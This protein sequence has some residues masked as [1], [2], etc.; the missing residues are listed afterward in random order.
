MKTNTTMHD[1]TQ[2]LLLEVHS[3]MK[4]LDERSQSI[5]RQVEKTNGRVTIL[6][7]DVEKVKNV[8]EN[9]VVKVGAGVTIAATVFASF[10]SRIFP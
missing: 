9:L 5:L 7:G 3:T 8:Q 4:V 10:V 2:R 1:D 6:E